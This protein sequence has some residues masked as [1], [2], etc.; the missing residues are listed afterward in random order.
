LEIELIN[1]DLDNKR[2]VNEFLVSEIVRLKTDTKVHIYT[3]DFDSDD[4][5]QKFVTSN[6]SFTN[7][8]YIP[9][10]LVSVSSKVVF[11]T[12]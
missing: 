9:A 3:F 6:K 11:D 2:L 5:L 4:S 7:K 8:S 10:D 12:K 1:I